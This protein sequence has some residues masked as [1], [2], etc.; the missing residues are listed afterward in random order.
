MPLREERLLENIEPGSLFGYVQCDS[1]VPENLRVSIVNFP[2]IFKNN[3]VGS[4]DLGPFMTRT[5]EKG[6][7]LIRPRRMLKSSY[8]LE[9][10]TIITP[11]LHFYPD[12]GLVF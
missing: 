11:I 7:L 5:A 1:E 10:G 4:D 12:L 6:G 3:N 2:H 9:N 8:F